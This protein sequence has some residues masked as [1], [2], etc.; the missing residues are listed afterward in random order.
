VTLTPLVVFCAAS[1]DGWPRTVRLRAISR[2]TWRSARSCGGGVIGMDGGCVCAA[3]SNRDP[4]TLC[5][6]CLSGYLVDDAACTPARIRA[7]IMEPSD[8]ACV[9]RDV[10][11]TDDGATC[12]G[13]GTCTQIVMP[14][15]PTA[16]SGRAIFACVCVDGWTGA[17]CATRMRVAECPPGEAVRC[18]ATLRPPRPR[19]GLVNVTVGQRHGAGRWGWAWV[20]D[21]A[22][23]SRARGWG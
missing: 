13:H 4:A 15:D 1:A 19:A 3:G 12:S 17:E 18:S 14:Q 2:V 9:I 23:I 22:C 20:R 11:V 21:P 6:K 16:I 8:C 7:G 10:C 5:T